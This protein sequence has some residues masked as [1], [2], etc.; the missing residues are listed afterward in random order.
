MLAARA[1]TLNFAA[2]LLAGAALSACSTTNMHPNLSNRLPAGQAA[3]QTASQGRQPGGQGGVYKVGKPYQ[4]GGIWY[5]P[6]E[7]PTY[8]ATGV[9][10]WY[11]QDFHNKATANGEV[12]DMHAVS[13]AHTTLPMPSIVEVTNLD[14]GRKIQVRMNDRGPFVGGRIIDLSY[15]AARQLGYENKG[16][17]N[18]RVRYVGPAP[19]GVG[20]GQ[21]Y[22]SVSS[23][24]TAA[25][26]VSAPFATA[27]V[28]ARPVPAPAPVAAQSLPP[29]AV[30]PAR[31]APA[32][33]Q[34]AAATPTYGAQNVTY[35]PTARPD[36][37]PPATNGY[38]P[39]T[40]VSATSPSTSG[41][42]KVQ[43]GAFSDP[44]KAQAV[45][46]QLAGAGP[47][48][49][50]TVERDGATLYRVMVQASA[51]EGE[52]WALRDRVAAYGYADARVIRPF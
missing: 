45:A 47:A 38:P 50:E 49:V 51:D 26:P 27:P 4:V 13:A 15:E 10:S 1:S 24:P 5:V 30:P 25:T 36:Y 46:D 29:I 28:A 9:A 34:Y 8:D 52:A 20:E 31:P 42:Y 39:V 17:A 40:A 41:L 37:R 48:R 12:F 14:N 19:L 35:A 44:G 21:R 6:K 7:E 43:A 11:G 32:P 33:T 16:L 22:A 2:L 23:S 18:V 3:G